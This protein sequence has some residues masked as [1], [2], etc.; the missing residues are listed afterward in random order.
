MPSPTATATKVLT[1]DQIAGVAWNAGFRDE[2]T[3][4][5][6]VAVALAESGG[7]TLAHNG[8]AGTG[9]NSY[10]LWQINMI[11]AM[12]PAR[13][14][15]FDIASNTALYDPAVNAKAAWVISNKG[16]NWAPWSVFKS[17]AYMRHINTGKS[18]AAKTMAMAKAAGPDWRNFIVPGL[19]IGSIIDSAGNVVGNAGAIKDAIGAKF[20]IGGSVTAAFNAFGQTLFKAGMN[21][22]ALVV[23]VVLL[24][25]GVIILMRQPLITA[26]KTVAGVAGPGKVANAAKKVGKVL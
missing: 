26:T 17:N 2:A 18:A 10:G 12:G 25:L 3:L 19:P 20:D 8:N 22:G 4:A 24:I 7:N 5:R 14:V 1:P 23:A 16:K 13:R 11:G 15:A 6:A 21:M 9:D